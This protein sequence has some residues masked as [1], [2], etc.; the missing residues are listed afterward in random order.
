MGIY[1]SN[2]YLGE[3][4]DY[5]SEIPV[6]EAYDAAFGCAHILA[7][8]QVNDMALFESTIYNDIAEVR[9]IQEGYGYVNENAFTSVLKKLAE[10]FKKLLG[11]IKGIF[12]AF[13]A[14]LTG[15][16]K[17]GKDLVKKYEKQIIKY[18]NWKDFKC[19]KVREPKK[20]I[21]NL[22]EA[23]NAVF[24]AQK[25]S[26]FSYSINTEMGLASETQIIPALDSFGNLKTPKKV[27]DADAE[28]IKEILLKR[29]LSNNIN[30]TEESEIHE[31]VMNYL[32]EDEDTID[33]NDQVKSASYFSANWI[34]TLLSEGEKWEKDVK[35]FNDKLE[36][37]INTIIDNLNKADNNLAK[38]MVDKGNKNKI[39]QL[40]DRTFNADAGDYKVQKGNYDVNARIYNN[41]N[42][43]TVNIDGKDVEINKGDDLLN[44]NYVEKNENLQK[45]IH[46]MQKI[47]TNEQEVITKITS[48]YMTVVKFS[49]ANAR[50][51]WTAAAAW[52]SGVHKESVEYADAMGDV[53]AEQFYTNM[54]SIH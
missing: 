44:S 31:E 38:F 20:S 25:I 15:A 8:C 11:K 27:I 1:T 17:D 18:A 33:G 2:R 36:K 30:V 49:L 28:D 40:S 54:E 16:F 43:K 34:K 26:A 3:A 7:D 50:R 32:F 47:A 41:K 35:K 23:I 37:N 29:Y 42:K 14:K 46:A 9:S 19:T 45:A 12:K 6:N 10:A 21:S 52:S 22:K 53:A 5:A 48:E 4:Y 51:V 39:A 13:I 24:Q